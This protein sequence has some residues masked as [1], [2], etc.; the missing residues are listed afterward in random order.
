MNELSR[1]HSIITRRASNIGCLVQQEE[2]SFPPGSTRPHYLH[3]R[4]WRIESGHRQRTTHFTTYGLTVAAAILISSPLRPGERC[5]PP[6]TKAE[7]SSTQNRR[8]Y[9]CHATQQALQ[10][11]PL[12]YAEYGRGSRSQSV[13][14]YTHLKAAQLKAAS[15]RNI[16]TQPRQT[17]QREASRCRRSLS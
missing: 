12:E 5:A 13:C 1:T 14:R 9:H 8:G 17:V 6:R 4:R 3:G 2:F 10:C 11:N 7:D 15:C 16:Q